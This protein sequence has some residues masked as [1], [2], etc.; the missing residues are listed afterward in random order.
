A[1][2]G[3][4]INAAALIGRVLVELD[5]AASIDLVTDASWTCSNKPAKV[6]GGLGVGPWQGVQA[7]GGG[8]QPNLWTCYR[9]SFELAGK[10]ATAPARIA[11]DSKYWLWV[12]GELVVREGGV[13]RGPNP[14][15]TYFDVVDLA[16][17]LVQGRNQIAVLAW[18]FGKDGFSHKNSGKPGFLFEMQAGETTVVSDDS[19]RTIRH[20]SFGEASNTPNFRLPESSVRFDARHEPTGWTTPGFD[21][22]SWKSPADFGAPPTAPWNRLW[23]RSIPQWKDFGLKDYEN[24]AELP[25]QGGAEPITAKLP[26]N[27]QITP[28]LRVS[29]PAG[30]MIQMR[31]DNGANE[32][33]AEYLTREGE[34]EFETPAWMSGHAVVYQ[35]PE[36]VR[37]LGLKYRESGFGTEFTGRFACDNPFLNKLAMMCERT[38]YINMRDTFFD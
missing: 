26:Y 2:D 7:A 32:I 9:K 30:V 23:E 15:D 5:G 14:Q 31:T 29:A 28:W 3:G 4:A 36:G 24:A 10:P 12:N 38:L 1:D 8:A 6:I 19:W 27:A 22:A 17:H 16:P 37:I 35:I 13:K 21:D 34:Q 25:K 11:V 18:F 20:P 33:F